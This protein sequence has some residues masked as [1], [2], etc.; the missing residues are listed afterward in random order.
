MQVSI[1]LL[2]K[3]IMDFEIVEGKVPRSMVEAVLDFNILLEPDPM[4]Q[5]GERKYKVNTLVWDD[6]IK[7]GH[8][9]IRAYGRLLEPATLDR[10]QTEFYSFTNSLK[11]R[12]S[13]LTISVARTVLDQAWNGMNGWVS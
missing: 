9:I 3:M 2:S 4:D 13:P 11:Y 12:K 6:T 5:D 1:P 10:L 8:L 7:K